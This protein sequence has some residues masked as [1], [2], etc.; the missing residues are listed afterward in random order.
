M[1]VAELAGVPYTATA[2]TSVAYAVNPSVYTT[3]ND[4]AN[5]RRRLLGFGGYSTL[6]VRTLSEI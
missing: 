2:I 5:N 6:L 3:P 1:V 4:P